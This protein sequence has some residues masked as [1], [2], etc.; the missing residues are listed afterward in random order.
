MSEAIFLPPRLTDPADLRD[1]PGRAF[2]PGYDALPPFKNIPYIPPIKDQTGRNSCVP[3]A[4]ASLIEA[5]YHEI[6]GARSP[7]ALYYWARRAENHV[8]QDV[9]CLPRTAYKELMARGFPPEAFW[10]YMGWGPKWK[11]MPTYPARFK[12]GFVRPRGYARLVGLEELKRAIVAGVGFTATIPITDDFSRAGESDGH[13]NR[14]KSGT[15][16]TGAH[17][18]FFYGYSDSIMAE[19]GEKGALFASNSLGTKWG[20]GGIC[21]VPYSYV[22]GN[23]LWDT[24]TIY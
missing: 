4:I 11:A 22:T 24:W 3:H 21:L 9:G 15:P 12:G 23:A 6:I 8:E 7:L 18:M 14:W 10:S 20:N 1:H 16:E 5:R 19:D 13:L 2:L 17:H